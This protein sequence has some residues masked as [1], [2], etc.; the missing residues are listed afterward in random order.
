MTNVTN[1]YAQA[2]LAFKAEFLASALLAHGGNR[3]E[4][5]RA[6]GMSRS[7]LNLLIRGL[8]IDVPSPRSTTSKALSA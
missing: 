6:L 4:T 7:A 1:L 8:R 3:V 2:V 5:A